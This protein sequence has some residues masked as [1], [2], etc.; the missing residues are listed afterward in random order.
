MV[1]RNYWLAG[2]FTVLTLGG[3]GGIR[4]PQHTTLLNMVPKTSLPPL[5]LPRI[6]LPSLPSLSFPAR[7]TREDVK[8]EESELPV[9]LPQNQ[10][11]V[12]MGMASW[13][14]P[15][16]HGKR[17]ANGEVYNQ[18][19]LTAAHRTLPLG[20]KAIV[21]NVETGESVEVRINDRGPY[22]YGRVIDLSYAAARRIS[23]WAAGTA[24]VQVSVLNPDRPFVSEILPSSYSLLLA[25]TTDSGEIATVMSEVGRHYPDAYVSLLSSGLLQYY[26]LRLGSFRSQREAA[27][28]ARMLKRVGIQALVVAEDDRRVER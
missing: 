17:T 25:S 18:H 2:T 12:Q 28:Q 4:Q 13:Y 26:Q 10:S 16:F 22:K 11:E 27:A 23:V 21:T 8:V 9:I 14:G 7:E 15:R 24:P 20:T 5:T 6:S 1:A 19:G 3:C